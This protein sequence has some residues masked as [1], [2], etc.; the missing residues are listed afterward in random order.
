M[1]EKTLFTKI[2]DGEL[3]ADIIYEDDQCICI[4]D[5]KPQAPTHVLLI[6]RKP[7]PTLADASNEDKA[8]LG[9]LLLKIGDIARLLKVDDGF[10]VVVNNGEKGGQVVFHLHLHLLANK[11]FSDNSL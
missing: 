7:I 9:H 5:I 8:L 2:I 1:P 3:P 6:P 4:R 10:R 11:I